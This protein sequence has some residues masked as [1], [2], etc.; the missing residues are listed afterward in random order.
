MQDNRRDVK[1]T[2]RRTDGV[3]DS[4]TGYNWSMIKKMEDI[5]LTFWEGY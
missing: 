4:V 3:I 5:G 1:W 2:P